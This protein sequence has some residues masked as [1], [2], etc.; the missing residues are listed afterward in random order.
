MA[1]KS[2]TPSTKVV[3][4]K[5]GGFNLTDEQEAIKKFIDKTD[6]NL[7][8]DA[9]AG[10]GKSSTI[11]TVAPKGS[12]IL[13]FNR[14]PADEMSK[15]ITDK[16]LPIFAD[17][18]HTWG[19]SCFAK[20][21]FV[22]VSRSHFMALDVLF[23]GQKPTKPEQWSLLSDVKAATSWAKA[24][25]V[26]P[27]DSLDTLLNVLK[28]V[29]LDIENGPEII[30]PFVMDML[31]RSCEQT[32]AKSGSMYWN[33]DL[34]DMQYL[35]FVK[36]WGAKCTPTLF[37][38]EG[39][40][41]NPIRMAL[42]KSWGERVIV[43]GDKFQAIY[44]FQGSMSN[45]LELFGTEMNAEILPLTTCWR[46]PSS[47][48][49][50]A[51]KIVPEIQDRPNCP[52]GILSFPEEVAEVEI[53]PE[54]GALIICRTNA[55]LISQ[56]YKLR[57]SNDLQVVMVSGDIPKVLKGF[58]GWD[59]KTNLNGA[60]ENR[61]AD[62]LEKKLK[63]A[64]TESQRMTVQDHDAAIQEILQNNPQLETVKDLHEI[65]DTEF[66]KPEPQDIA[67]NA[68]RLSSIHSSKGLEH[69]HVVLYGQ[70]LLPH[71]MATLPYELEQEY[72]LKYVGLTRSKNTLDIIEEV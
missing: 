66:T 33:I 21:P 58:I 53:N 59:F 35:P 6:R 14:Q 36:G 22:N 70:S 40:D 5:K 26:R 16:G 24:Q 3:K 12:V 48:L 45:S 49:D 32:K 38:D 27:D 20:N 28:D 13:C 64:K 55:P 29:R 31:Q 15:R 41:L 44:A 72:N 68:I 69:Q 34:D 56:Y 65:I 39:Q 61:Y 63:Y 8:V 67:E 62:K 43:V 42:A 51:R 1:K 47:H 10:T 7:I 2:S 37:V 23:K 54:T 60:W 52:K 46:C 19:K 30:T 18:F 25:A 50:L 4:S 17:T 9:K 71:P 11:E 57:K